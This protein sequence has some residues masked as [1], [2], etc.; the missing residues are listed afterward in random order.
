MDRHWFVVCVLVRLGLAALAW[1]LEPP[2]W[3]RVLMVAAAASVAGGM[4]ATQA[5]R[6][7]GGVAVWGDKNA[8]WNLYPH[9]LLYLA[10]AGAFALRWPQ[11]WL[12]LAVDVL[13]GIVVFWRKKSF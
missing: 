10:F 4:A 13:L 7:R 12:F 8:Y 3:G 9:A 5:E 6:D 11:A 2:A 1:R